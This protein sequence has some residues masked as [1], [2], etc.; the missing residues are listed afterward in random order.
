M[1]LFLKYLRYFFRYFTVTDLWEKKKKKPFIVAISSSESI[2]NS[3]RVNSLSYVFILFR[4]P[5][6]YLRYFLR[7]FIV[8]DL[9]E[10][11]KKKPF[12]VAISSSESILKSYRVNSLSYVF[13]VLP[14]EQL[15]K[16]AIIGLK[17]Y[18]KLHAHDL[19]ALSHIE[20]SS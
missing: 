7:Y 2:L 4:Y 9:S 18:E 17:Y 12:I 16:R 13:S 8:A 10:K 19:F 5:L 3:Y 11:K 15:N 20:I 1:R 6:K 14:M